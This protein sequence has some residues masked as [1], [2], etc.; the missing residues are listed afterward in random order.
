[1]KFRLFLVLALTLSLVACDSFHKK[2]KT[3]PAA[4]Q[5][6]KDASGQVSYEA[7]VGQLRKAVEKHDLQL[8]ASLMT[9][10]FGYLLDPTPSDPGSGEGVWAYWEANHLW[11]E[12]NRVVHERFVPFR[13]FM[14]A[15]PRFVTDPDYTGYRAGIIQVNGAWKFAYFVSGN[16]EAPQ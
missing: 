7:F 15:P 16:Q 10:D 12:L 3:K 5:P 6:I 11:P 1:M 2:K 8:L 14:V 13:D 4:P 9:S